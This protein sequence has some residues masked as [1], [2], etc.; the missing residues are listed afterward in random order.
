MPLAPD[1]LDR[2]SDIDDPRLADFRLMRDRDL[3][4]RAGR[5]GLFIG[6]SLLVVERM[7]RV[8][9]V[10]KTVLVAEDR[11]DEVT[12]LDGIDRAACVVAAPRALVAEVTGFYFHRGVIASGFREPLESRTVDQ[13][14]AGASCAL[15]CD[16]IS[17]MDNA[18]ALFRDG[19][20]FGVD[21]VVLSRDSHDPL[22]RKCLRTSMGH[23][24]S[25]P[26]ARVGAGAKGLAGANGTAGAVRDMVAAGWI[27]LGTSIDA[28]AEPLREWVDSIAAT[29][30]PLRVAVVVGHEH[31]GVSAN[32]LE[33]CSRRVRIPMATGVDSLNVSVAAAVVLHEVTRVG[34]RA[35][36][37]RFDTPPPG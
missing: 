31:R 13:V 24:L 23:A 29:T 32:V 8:P 17:N 37:M 16:D 12:A 36:P 34:A 15:I 2:A 9:G 26:F 11:V 22:Y 14:L 27:V 10:L 5:P 19:A 21:A 20:A 4:G 30:A 28:S 35:M 25:V 7:A 3:L 6:E 33:A 1:R 18:G